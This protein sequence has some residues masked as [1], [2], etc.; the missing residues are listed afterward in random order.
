MKALIKGEVNCAELIKRKM[1][2]N[3]IMSNILVFR[4][5]PSAGLEPARQKRPRILS[6]LCLPIPS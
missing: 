3:N 2:P 6:P 5:V 4:M 1:L